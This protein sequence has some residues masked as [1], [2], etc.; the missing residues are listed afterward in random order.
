MQTPIDLWVYYIFSGCCIYKMVMYTLQL[1]S[2]CKDFNFS[3]SFSKQLLLKCYIPLCS[4][5]LFWLFGCIS[6]LLHFKSSAISTLD[7]FTM[8]F[9]M[10][11]YFL[12][13]LSY[14]RIQSNKKNNDIEDGLIEKYVLSN[15]SLYICNV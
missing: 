7:T 9:G 6:S 15:L 5:C 8:L 12:F 1:S 2:S 13:S 14:I 4:F 3:S 11:F 10:S